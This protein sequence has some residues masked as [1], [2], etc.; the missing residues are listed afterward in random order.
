MEDMC[1]GTPLEEHSVTSHGERPLYGS[2][3][4]HRHR[5]DAARKMRVVVI[6]Q[7]WI[8]NPEFFV[9]AI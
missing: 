1:E 3:R 5:F 4:L 2:L 8:R 6:C 9:A 7:R